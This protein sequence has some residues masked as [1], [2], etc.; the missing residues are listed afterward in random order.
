MSIA[1]AVSGENGLLRKCWIAYQRG[2]WRLAIARRLS[3]YGYGLRYLLRR[4]PSIRLHL[5]PY[6][7]P[8][9]ED[10][11]LV[12]RIMDAYRRAKEA[13]AGQPAVY[14][15]ASIWREQLGLAYSAITEGARDNDLDKFHHFLANF[16]SWKVYHGVENTTLLQKYA[17][18]PITRRYL[19]H[20]VFRQRLDRWARFNNGRKPTSALS[21][22]MHGNQSGAYID[23]QFV[24]AG[25]FFVEIY[26][27]ILSGILSDYDRPVVAELG[28][29]YGKFAYFICR[30]RPVCTYIDFD[31]PETLC[32]ATYYF[33]K[34][35][36]E[37]RFL[38]Y[39]EAPYAS[40]RH[41]EYDAIFM[42]QFEIE[43]L[44]PKS[45]DLFVNKNSL[46]EMDREAVD[47]Y[48]GFACNASRYI[49]HLNHERYP[50]IYEDGAR[51]YLGF[52][53][54]IPEKQFKLLFRYPDLDYLG[55]AFRA[56]SMDIFLYLYERRV[57]S[58]HA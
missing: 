55:D 44:E 51:G 39:G 58:S 10:R 2:D 47:R 15:P 12:G 57:D 1:S 37:K 18:N 16:G 14:R 36:P 5:P 54:P 31:L 22:P 26:G 53:Y 43:K 42:P 34:V 25:S 38:L 24:G 20:V 8:D 35:Y 30:N 7:Q 29:G 49:F 19:E 40:S 3:P 41:D 45:V 11:A 13:E 27:S 28:G 23:G 21:Y 33:M 46:G 50:N 17:G 4:S 6:Q 52:E 48:L 9:V 32:L 56:E